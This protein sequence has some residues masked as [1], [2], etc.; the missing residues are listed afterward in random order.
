PMAE[1]NVSVVTPEREVYSGPASEVR[2]PGWEGEFDVLPGHD[3]VLALMRGGVVHIA[4]PQGALRYIAGRGFAEVSGDL[5]TVLTDSC[6][7]AEDV[8][9][10]AALTELA[11]AE[12]T[13]GESSADTPAWDAAVERR[14]IL[15][16]R[17]NA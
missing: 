6:E 11:A 15:Q 16:A 7:S 2:V 1:L 12:K 5:V 17:L 9:K 10:A 3:L 4:T 8:D 13:L 14:E